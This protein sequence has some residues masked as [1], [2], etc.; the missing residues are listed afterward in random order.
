MTS[1]V[2]VTNVANIMNGQ[3]EAKAAISKLNRKKV[4]THQRNNA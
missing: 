3:E 4:S 2:G 1:K